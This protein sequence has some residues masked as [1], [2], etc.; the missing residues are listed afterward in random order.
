MLPV[1]SMLIGA[2]GWIRFWCLSGSGSAQLL[3]ALVVLC[4]AG[5]HLSGSGSAILHQ[6]LLAALV[7]LLGAAGW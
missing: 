1:S 5:G 4:G 2:G 7:V 3:A 6:K